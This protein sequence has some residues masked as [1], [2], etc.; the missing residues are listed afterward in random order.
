MPRVLRTLPL[1]SVAAALLLSAC[2]SERAPSGERTGATSPGQGL[3]FA[4]APG[5]AATESADSL[6]LRAQVALDRLGFSSG[7]IDGK[8]GQ[9]YGLALSGFQQAR[10]LP[11]SGRL[12]PATQQAL[13]SGSDS[14]GTRNVVIP[15]DFAKGPFVPDLPKDM[16]GQARFKHLGYRSMAEALAERFHTTPETLL[17][18][19]GA[20]TVLGA[21]RTIRVRRSR[22]RTCDH[23]GGRER[24]GRYPPA[25]WR[26]GGAT[27]GRSRRGRQ[28]RWRAAGL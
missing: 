2:H 12:D 1:V 4:D 15:A 23:R 7:V 14:A 6:V 13:L 16:A 20:G 24:L 3:A 21:G 17:A 10:G 9:S 18:L 5:G 22:C 28:V 11:A 26:R 25:P 27:Q 8:E 19:N